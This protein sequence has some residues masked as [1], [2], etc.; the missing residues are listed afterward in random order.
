VGAL[1]AGLNRVGLGPLRADISGPELRRAS[2]R[3]LAE[4]AGRLG[5]EADHVLFGHTHRSGPW[6]RDDEAEW[7][8]SGTTHLHNCGNWVREAFLGGAQPQ[9]GP[10]RSGTALALGDD[11]PPRLLDLLG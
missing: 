4:V 2:L 11:G 10:Y 6:P 8:A 7:R 1:V 3:A 5:I 9:R